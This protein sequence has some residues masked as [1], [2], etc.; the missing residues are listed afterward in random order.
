MTNLNPPHD[1]EG[2]PYPDFS[3]ITPP[4]KQK[5]NTAIK[6]AAIVGAV[7]VAL[8]IIG[9]IAGGGSKSHGSNANSGGGNSGASISSDYASWK[10]GFQPVWSQTQADWNTTSTALG[11]GDSTTASNG[12][13]SLGQD[14]ASIAS[15]N[16]SPDSQLNSDIYQLSSDLQNVAYDGEQLVSGATTDQTQFGNDCNAVKADESTVTADL[17]RLNATY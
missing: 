7:I 8:A 17:T 5:S 12:F 11:N 15:F 3:T 4:A 13:S 10:T 1:H 9:A 6:V 14:A 2:V 16:N